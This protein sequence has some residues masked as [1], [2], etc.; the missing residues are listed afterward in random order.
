MMTSIST[1][2]KSLPTK[3]K[4]AL[5]AGCTIGLLVTSGII[6]KASSDH[7]AASHG[8]IAAPTVTVTA[9]PSA[10]PTPTPSHA[11]PGACVVYYGSLNA[12]YVQFTRFTAAYGQWGYL[13][14]RMQGALL[15]GDVAEANGLKQEIYQMDA[16][17]SEA[18]GKIIDNNQTLGIEKKKCEEANK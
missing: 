5:G 7:G 6:E 15:A 10:A 2:W 8:T 11:I 14:D 4:I 16:G 13:T 1:L 9:R 17:A 3:S 12:Q 18:L